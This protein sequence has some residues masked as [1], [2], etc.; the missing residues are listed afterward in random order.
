M[1]TRISYTW[2]LPASG[3]PKGIPRPVCA[4]YTISICHIERDTLPS[5]LGKPLPKY[6]IPVFILAQLAV[7]KK[8]QGQGLGDVTLINA[9]RKCV[10]LSEQGI[11]PVAAIILDVADNDAMA[12]YRRFSDF[13]LLSTTNPNAL[14][15]LYLPIRVAE[16]L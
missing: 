3:I 8:C 12:F 9:L 10:K 13:R 15:R 5:D 4:W 1:D 7:D 16:K 6:P 14:P 11:V 2:V